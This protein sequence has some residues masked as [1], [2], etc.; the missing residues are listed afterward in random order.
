MSR[1]GWLPCRTARPRS[2]VFSRPSPGH[3]EVVLAISD[4]AAASTRNMSQMPEWISERQRKLRR[5]YGDIW[6]RLLQ[7]AADAGQLRPGL[8]LYAAQGLIIGALSWSN[9]WWDPERRS[10]DAWTRN[11]QDM[12]RYGIGR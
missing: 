9:E 5:E 2:I 6:R 4:Y 12:V 8:S 3:L 7:D 1:P 11:A 10:L